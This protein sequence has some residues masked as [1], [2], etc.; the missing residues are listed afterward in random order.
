[1]GV[2][3]GNTIES[4][5][6]SDFTGLTSLNVIQAVNV[7]VTAGEGTAV[8][9][10]GTTGDSTLTG[11][12]SQTVTSGTAVTAS[13]SVGAVAV[14]GVTG[15]ISIDD[16]TSVT[17][18]DAGGSNNITIGHNA[19]PSG[20]VIVNDTN[21]SKGDIKV[22]GGTDV[23][24]TAASANGGTVVVGGTEA[25]SGVTSITVT[26]TK[27]VADANTATTLGIVQATGGTAVTVD[28][29][30]TSSAAAAAKGTTNTNL[31]V[32][33]GAI[34]VTGDKHT[35]TVT[36]SQDADVTAVNYKAA[37]AATAGVQQVDTV[38]FVAMLANDTMTVGGLIFTASVDLTA[39]QVAS[40]FANL[41]AGATQGSAAASLGTYSGAFGDYTTGAAS[42]S[43][44]T[45]TAVDAV[46]GNTAITVTDTTV[47]DNVSSANTTEGL[48]AVKAVAAVDGVMGITAGLV[49]I[50]GTIA[51]AD[52]VLTTVSIDGY[53][54]TSQVVSDALTSLTLAN[55]NNGLIVYNAEAETLALSLNNIGTG[56]TINLDS[57]G[58]T[59]TAL[60]IT[61]TGTASDVTLTAAAVE[62]LTVAGTKTLDLTGATLTA[63]ETVT[64]SG[65]A[66]LT[67]DASGANVTSVSTEATT[68]DS[69]ITVDADK[70]TFTGGN[71][72]DTVTLSST[73]VDKAVSLGGGDD[74][75]TL[76][77]GTTAVTSTLSGGLGTDTLVMAAADA[78][79]LSGSTAF[80]AKID[81]FEKLS[82]GQAA[83]AVS[84]DLANL[85]GINYVIS[86][87]GAAG[88]AGSRETF[89][90]SANAF[91]EVGSD[92][93]ATFD[94][95]TYTYIASNYSAY[96]SAFFFAGNYN[97]N[98]ISPSYALIGSKNNDMLFEAT[99]A[100]NKTDVTSADFVVNAGT[101]DTGTLSFTV[102][103][104]TDGTAATAGGALTLTNMANAGTLEL[105]D[106][107][108][109][110]TV[111]M[112]DATGAA[113]SFNIITKVSGTDL[114][115]GTVD[116]QDVETVIITATDTSTKASIELATLEL[117]GDAKTVVVTGNADLTLTSAITALK[118]VD[119]S[120]L[121]GN[122]TFSSSVASATI[123][124]G[125]GDDA[126]T[127]SGSSQHLT[128]GDGDDNI[129]GTANGQIVSGGDGDDSITGSGDNQTISGGDGD[130]SITATGDSQVLTGGAGDDL[131][132]FSSA[133]ST[134]N[135]YATITD[136][137]VGDK[138]GFDAATIFN[139]DAIAMASTASFTDYANEAIR[140]S[141]DGEVSWFQYGGDTYAVENV[142]IGGGASPN[143]EDTF[144]NGADVIVR[145]TGLVDLSDSSFSSAQN[146]L[147]VV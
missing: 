37:T 25:P 13:D 77:T 55:S 15:D 143:D 127:G 79:T 85:D 92:T 29:T 124:G 64:V 80:G 73:T 35:T 33:Q 14:S 86:A 121:T 28:V 141:S 102:S 136:L 75:L 144:T 96:G 101:A 69:T 5:D 11:G 30:A 51:N 59:Y 3:A 61:T 27:Y 48:T 100:G 132:S 88:T 49:N 91:T 50:D 67:I 23:T 20:A 131:F 118:T 139:A 44:V 137:Q 93:T 83:G 105:T 94:G 134:L 46:T 24:I 76:A 19:G 145:I 146:S 135:H 56:S 74:S 53:G 54:G 40:A 122:L 107:A 70:A 125:D 129:N 97:S 47:K 98:A 63:L 42:S 147:M 26:G 126:I 72:K 58:K 8:S 104:V 128:G 43:K 123:T 130:D 57:G 10:S 111:T 106:A 7:N 112:T 2:T 39:A 84:I 4:F 22:D 99:S 103:G 82:L 110:T 41:D 66:G 138:I 109:S 68:G 114:D 12:A 18:T 21:L 65:S 6:V 117:V 142:A 89:T 119:A 115:F 62:T 113:D 9:V 90:L 38:T 60:N 36:V 120:G 1:V 108:T 81:G 31:A 16:G 133:T 45:A 140:T 34:T 78:A 87:G 95:Y 71:G 17:V 52:D 116:V 32:T